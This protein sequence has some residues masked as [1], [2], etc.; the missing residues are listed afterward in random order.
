MEIR[1]TDAEPK[2]ICEDGYIRR[3]D[4]CGQYGYNTNTDCLLCG[5]NIDRR[6][7]R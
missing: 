7:D 2:I 1:L 6:A 3:V 5:L 4:S